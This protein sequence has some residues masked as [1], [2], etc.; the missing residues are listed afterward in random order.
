VAIINLGKIVA[1]GSPTKLKA[2]I[3]NESINLAFENA[4][5]AAEAKA[6]LG[7]LSESIQIDRDILRL[8]VEGAAEKIPQVLKRLDAA[9]I[10]PISL[11]L[12]QPTLDD[13]FLQVTG[14]RLEKE[15]NVETQGS[16]VKSN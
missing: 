15:Q 10:E 12:T 11:T 9:Q 14:Q 8:Y 3:G 5:V 2:G 6:H 4:R 1:Q 13:V 7:S 16:F